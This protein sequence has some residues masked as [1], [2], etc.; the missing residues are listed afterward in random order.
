MNDCAVALA[1]SALLVQHKDMWLKVR[2]LGIGWFE[3]DDPLDSLCAEP[4]VFRGDK[5]DFAR[6]LRDATGAVMAVLIPAR[7]EFDDLADIAAWLPDKNKICG[8]AQSRCS[9]RTTSMSP[10]SMIL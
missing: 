5:F 1:E 3:S 10:A 8:V 6:D 4:V 9:A 7:D 2:H